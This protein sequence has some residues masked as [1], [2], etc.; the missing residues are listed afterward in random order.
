MWKLKSSLSSLLNKSFHFWQGLEN[1]D[2]LIV[3]G[4]SDSPSHFIQTT[5]DYDWI[6][7]RICIQQ[8]KPCI[9]YSPFKLLN[10]AFLLFLLV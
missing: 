3:M 6:L 5:K 1:K 4:L 2:L 7:N 10:I 8:V 9:I